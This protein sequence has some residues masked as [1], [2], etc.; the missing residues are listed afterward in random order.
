VL[1]IF[2]RMNELKMPYFE[3]LIFAS[4]GFKK[5]F[6]ELILWMLEI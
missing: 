1:N 5:D 3:E 4:D 6:A 2:L